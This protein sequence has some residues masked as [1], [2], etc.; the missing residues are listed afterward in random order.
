MNKGTWHAIGAY[1][2]WGLFP[3]YWKALHQVPA[4]QLISHRVVWSSLVLLGVLG[5]SRQLR[6]FRAAVAD[7][8]A[9]GL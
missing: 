6:H 2:I 4:L 8:R 7:R 1:G 9:L 3:L 5:A